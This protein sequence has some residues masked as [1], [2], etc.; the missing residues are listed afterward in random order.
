MA[1][2]IIFVILIV[3][4]IFSIK[5][6]AKKLAQGCYGGSVKKGRNG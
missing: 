6:F 3:V 2:G 4:G 1:I 5:H